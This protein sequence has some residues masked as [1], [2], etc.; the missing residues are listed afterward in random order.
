[1]AQPPTYGNEARAGDNS[2]YCLCR[3]GS[4]VACLLNLLGSRIPMVA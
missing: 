3:A 4:H 2:A 1:M